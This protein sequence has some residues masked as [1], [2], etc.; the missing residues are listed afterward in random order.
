MISLEAS[1]FMTPVKLS[2]LLNTLSTVQIHV[3]GTPEI[4]KAE[5]NAALA[6]YLYANTFS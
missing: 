6:V 2:S 4:M 1:N 5:I 3:G